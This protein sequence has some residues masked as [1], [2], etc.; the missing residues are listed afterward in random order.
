MHLAVILV[1]AVIVAGLLIWGVQSLNPKGFNAA[2]KQGVK[3]A[4]NTV[5]DKIDKASDAVEQGLK[6]L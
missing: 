4:A 2:A 3:G 1:L 5:A 6:K